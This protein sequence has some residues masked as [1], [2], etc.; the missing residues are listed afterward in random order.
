MSGKCVICGT[1]V[2]DYEPEYCCS[3][4]ECGCMGLP[5][6]P[7]ICDK[8]ECNEKIFGRRDKSV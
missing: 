6:E 1:Y 2:K 8:E 4:R 5:I 7:C 3:G